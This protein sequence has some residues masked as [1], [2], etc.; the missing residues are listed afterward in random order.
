MP[1]AGWLAVGAATAAL[2]APWMVTLPLGGG[3]ALVV[4]GCVV[5][6]VA[7]ATR[8]AAP[9]ALG[10][11]AATILLRIGLALTVAPPP[12]PAPLPTA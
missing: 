2:I 6:T 4:T 7:L 9:M 8:R 5:A 11:G 12:E 10:L 3:L 1:R